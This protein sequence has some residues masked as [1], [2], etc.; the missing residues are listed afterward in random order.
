MPVEGER[1]ETPAAGAR[2]S[3]VND[4]AK[5]F[6]D[7]NVTRDRGGHTGSHTCTHV[8]ETRAEIRQ[9]IMIDE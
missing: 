2:G 5:R 4:L 1:R 6:I 8:R 7:I 3:T 9:S